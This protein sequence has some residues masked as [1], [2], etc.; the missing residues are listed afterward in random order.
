MFIIPVRCISESCIKIKI[1]LIFIIILCHTSK[2]FMKAF[3]AFMQPFE[4]AKKCE[5]KKLSHFFLFVR[6]RGLKRLFM[7]ME[8]LR[9]KLFVFLKFVFNSV[10][11]ISQ[12]SK[13]LTLK[14]IF[15][16]KICNTQL[17]WNV[18]HCF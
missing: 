14:D 18:D 3:K 5:N 2:S 6:D 17:S 13:P 4:T 9:E 7:C 8:S 16:I 10:V 1:N 12:K 15:I 11:L